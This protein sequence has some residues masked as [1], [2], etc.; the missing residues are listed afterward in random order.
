MAA[1]LYHLVMCRGTLGHHLFQ[2]VPIRLEA[3]LDKLV[4]MCAPGGKV[5]IIDSD[6]LFADEVTRQRIERWAAGRPELNP[7][8]A[9][10]GNEPDPPL[11]EHS[12]THALVLERPANEAGVAARPPAS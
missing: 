3:Y 12:Y 5:I 7:R 11:G 9:E 6:P 1:G 10:F 2:K 4:G 8:L